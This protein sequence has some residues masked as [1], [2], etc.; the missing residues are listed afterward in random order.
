[1][2]GGLHLVVFRN[3]GG[4][5]G[6]PLARLPGG[7][8]LAPADVDTVRFAARHPLLA[9][10]PETWS[11]PRLASHELAG[12]DAEWEKLTEPCCL[13]TRKIGKGSILL[14]E[15]RLIELA[16]HPVAERLLRNILASSAAK[17]VLVLAGEGEIPAVIDTLGI[18]ARGRVDWR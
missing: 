6:D 12:G 8:K 15:A 2:A 4:S 14:V 9:G 10:L 7:L 1:V 18:P 16:G 13:A 17:P 11:S 5:E 3:Q